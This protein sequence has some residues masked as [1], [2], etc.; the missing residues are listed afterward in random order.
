M[1][2]SA[3]CL[4]GS[5]AWHSL[6][7]NTKEAMNP[8]FFSPCFLTTC[9]FLTFGDE[10]VLVDPMSWSLW[11][12][13]SIWKDTRLDTE[14]PPSPGLLSLLPSLKHFFTTPLPLL[15]V[16][17][18]L[19]VVLLLLRLQLLDEWRLEFLDT[20][21]PRKVWGISWPLENKISAGEGDRVLI[22]LNSKLRSSDKC[23]VFKSLFSM[24]MLCLE[25]MKVNWRFYMVRLFK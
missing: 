17:L 21:G 8:L 24:V 13:G 19:L 5:S 18:L 11:S 10:V 20:L 23:L 12:E 14:R 16:L 2:L 4:E 25:K 15:L 6:H 9:M 7:A 22:W 3:T 1:I